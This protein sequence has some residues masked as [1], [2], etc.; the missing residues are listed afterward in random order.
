MN[1]DTLKEMAE[2]E[3]LASELRLQKWTKLSGNDPLQ[4][5]YATAIRETL[6]A[7]TRL[8]QSITKEG[9]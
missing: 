7:Y 2:L 5:D 3:R 6:N 8:A 9:R 4:T 1:D